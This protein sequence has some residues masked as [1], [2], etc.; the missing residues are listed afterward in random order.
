MTYKLLFYTDDAGESTCLGWLRRLR[1]AKAAERIQDRLSRLEQGNL[2][3][4]KSLGD[5]LYELRF[6][7]GPGYRVYFGRVGQTLIVLLCGGDKSTQARDIATAR[8]LWNDHRRRMGD[9]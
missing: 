7:F 8:Q 4:H 5:N 1:D 9:A 3:D 6:T 2:G